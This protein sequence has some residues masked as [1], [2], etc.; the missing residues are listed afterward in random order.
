MK[1]QVRIASL[2]LLAVLCLTLAALPASAD[3]LYDNGPVNGNVT[4]WRINGG[5]VVSNSYHTSGSG[6]S[7][8][9]V[10]GFTFAVWELP[11]DTLTSVDWVVSTGPCSGPGGCGT[12]LGSGTASGA[13]L[14]DTFLFSNE[15]GYKI[16]VPTVDGATINNSKSNTYW[17]TLG[18][19]SASGDPV[20]WD[21][22]SGPS[23]AYDSALGTIPSEAFT[24]YG[25]GSSTPEPSSLLLLGSGV[26]GIGGLLRKR[27]FG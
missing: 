16:D 13:N 8:F 27:F 17:L 24:I 26:L 22:N 25:S 21:E 19:A 7:D 3:T 14:T 11:G 15:Y 20:Y 2:A 23:Q 12:I 1:T 18:N 6:G 10:T 5:F 4:A 9:T